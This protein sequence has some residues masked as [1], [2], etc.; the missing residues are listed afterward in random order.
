DF[1]KRITKATKAVIPVHMWGLPCDMKG[2]M[3]V[4]RKHKILVLED[5]CQAVGGGYDGKMLGSIGH[6]G[7]FSFNY[8]K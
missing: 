6:A 7:A 3:R 5:A 1:E 2:I 4:A 8:Y